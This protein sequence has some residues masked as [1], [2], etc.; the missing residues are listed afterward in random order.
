L[1]DKPTK[2]PRKIADSIEILHEKFV[3]YFLNNVFIK[4]GST[5]VMG[6][7]FLLSIVSWLAFWD[8][9]GI[10]VIQFGFGVLLLMI[11]LIGWE[12]LILEKFYSEFYTQINRESH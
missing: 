7:Y 1:L 3:K 4:A 9:S 11:I 2:K 6:F 10:Y 12:N 8:N 5:I